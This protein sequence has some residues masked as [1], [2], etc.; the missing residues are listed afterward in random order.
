MRSKR[1]GL[2]ALTLLLLLLCLPL[3]SPSKAARVAPQ[4]PGVDLGAFVKEIMVM[5]MEADHSQLAMWF[6]YE[7]FVASMMAQGASKSLAEKDSEFVK[8]F[9]IL[10]VQNKTDRPD[11]SSAYLGEK[12]VRARAVLRLA[13]G[14]EVT[15]LERMPPMLSA[16]LAAIKTMVTSEGDAGSANMHIVVFPNSTA[17]GKVIV[18]S[19]QRES[20]TLVLKAGGGFKETAFTWRTPFDAVAG[21]PPCSRCKAAMSSKWAYCPYD[22]QKLP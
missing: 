9:I 15:P 22:G 18:N 7:F 17:R 5:D 11:G 20:L 14:E 3:P 8:P 12:E 2:A 16:V 4:T 1:L 10:F 19:A 13:G 21:T 6:P